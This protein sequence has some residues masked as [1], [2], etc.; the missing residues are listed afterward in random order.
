MRVLYVRR[1]LHK[2]QLFRIMS[3]HTLVK[4]LMCVPCV[5]RDLFAAV[6]CKGTYVHTLGKSPMC[7]LCD[8]RFRYSSGLQRRITAISRHHD[9]FILSLR[10]QCQRCAHA[11]C[12]RAGVDLET[13]VRLLC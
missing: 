13:R 1:D 10:V 9:Q 7:V 2:K 5:R 6:A 4:G 12:A 3:V 11:D 8:K